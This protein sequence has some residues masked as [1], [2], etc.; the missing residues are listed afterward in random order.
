MSLDI[1]L[2]R[3]IPSGF[4]SNHT[5]AIFIESSFGVDLHG[6]VGIEQQKIVHYI[7]LIPL[8]PDAADARPEPMPVIGQ[9]VTMHTKLILPANR[10]VQ[11]VKH[12]KT[13]TFIIAMIVNR[14]VA[15][16]QIGLDNMTASILKL[17]CSTQGELNTEVS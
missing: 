14:L 11:A 15:V 6:S 9:P 13:A 12:I 3:G 10:T 7:V 1:Q 17:R 5:H 2:L 8:L 16:I 4:C